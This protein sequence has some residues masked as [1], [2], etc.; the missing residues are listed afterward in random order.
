MNYKV[1]AEK[2]SPMAKKYVI[3]AIASGG[4]VQMKVK[5]ASGSFK[6]SLE[7]L[8]VINRAALIK[9][10]NL[11]QKLVKGP[12][13]RKQKQQPKQLQLHQENLE[14]ALL[15]RKIQLQLKLKKCQGK[16]KSSSHH[17]K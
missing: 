6:L 14:L 16:R 10:L 11:N 1:D 5:G 2:L 9:M 13:E 4:L 3:S 17:Q 12:Q 8:L 15:K 7:S